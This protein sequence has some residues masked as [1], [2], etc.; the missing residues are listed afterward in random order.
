M[1][2]AGLTNVLNK[3]VSID[4][5]PG[6]MH[7][8][9]RL[10]AQRSDRRLVARMLE[11]G[12]YAEALSDWTDRSDAGPAIFVNFTNVGSRHAAEALGRRILKV[13]A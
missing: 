7:L 4:Q 6:G 2:T 12:L 13:M 8:I 11:E 9:L 3:H 5:K 10:R 1:T